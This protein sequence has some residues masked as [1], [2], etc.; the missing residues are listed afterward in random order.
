[1]SLFA[2]EAHAAFRSLDSNR[3]RLW[4]KMNA[5]SEFTCLISGTLF[6]LGPRKDGKGLMSCLGR[7]WDR[8]NAKWTTEERVVLK[9]LFMHNDWDILAF[10]TLITPFYLRRDLNSQWFRKW[11]IPRVRVRPKPEIVDPQDYEFEQELTNAFRNSSILKP[12]RDGLLN[13]E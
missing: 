5:W 3:A 9:K 4:D 7:D 6:P 1:L 11:I 2:D 13:F 10:R 8:K 12:G